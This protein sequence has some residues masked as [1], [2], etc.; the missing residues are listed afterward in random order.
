[1][2][3]CIIIRN[4]LSGRTKSFY[5]IASK[6]AK[7]LNQTANSSER[8][9]H[10]KK[11]ALKVEK[12]RTCS[13]VDDPWGPHTSRAAPTGLHSTSISRHPGWEP[14]MSSYPV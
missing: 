11:A 7:K 10:I 4:I 2:T 6:N 5:I 8:G 14:R 12:N 13:P 3:I 9:R 1:M